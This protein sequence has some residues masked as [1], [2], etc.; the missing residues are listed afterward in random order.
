M[1]SLLTALYERPPP[2]PPPPPPCLVVV[3]VDRVAVLL[4]DLAHRV[5]GLVHRLTIWKPTA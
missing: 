5:V 4:V 1:A 2:P 3:V